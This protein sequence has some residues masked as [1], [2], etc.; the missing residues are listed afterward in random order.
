MLNTLSGLASGFVGAIT[1][2]LKD[3]AK[4]TNTRYQSPTFK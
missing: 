2:V 1:K 3:E 4:A